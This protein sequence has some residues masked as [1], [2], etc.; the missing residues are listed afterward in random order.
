MSEPTSA[1]GGGA[2]ARVEA[3]RWALA[4]VRGRLQALAERERFGPLPP[5]AVVRRRELRAEAEDLTD[6]LR[7]ALRSRRHPDATA[8]A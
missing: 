3:L 4:R 2:A 1:T 5:G 8:L 6:A 7:Q